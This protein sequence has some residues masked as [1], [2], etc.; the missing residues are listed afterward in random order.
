M[1]AGA[2][3]EV[4]G[5]AETAGEV[6]AGSGAVGEVGKWRANTHLYSKFTPRIG[7]RTHGCVPGLGPGTRLTE[8]ALNLWRRVTG[9]AVLYSHFPGAWRPD[10]V[11]IAC[12]P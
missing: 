4:A 8:A 3:S 2:R 12:T 1:V 7:V 11:S 10:D 6:G 9:A 5:S